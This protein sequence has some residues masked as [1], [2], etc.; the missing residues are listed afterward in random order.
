MSETTLLSA[1]VLGLVE[2]LTEFL[3]VSSTGHLILLVDLIGFQGPPGH[4]FEV[5]I[6]L[7]AIMAV[8]VVYF[9][10]LAGVVFGL[11]VDRGARQFAVAVVLAF[12]PAA[13]IGVALHGVIKSVL[14]DPTVVSVALIV[15]GVAI[16]AIERWVRPVP[17]VFAVEAIRPRTALAIGLFQCLAMVPGV[18]RAGATIIGSLLIGLERRVAAEFSFFLAIPTMLGASVYDL[19]KNRDALGL[20]DG[21]FVGG[22]V[23]A[24]GFAV[25]FVVAALVVQTLIAFISR[26]GFTPFGWYRIA[27]GGAMLT[28]LYWPAATG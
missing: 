27:L 16:L 18:S 19:Y 6:Q 20:V 5:V 7:G 1:A 24:V 9:R 3:P 26:H 4:V 10:R 14:F 28:L 22:W 8:C 17:R 2:G 12:L 13:V 15:G 25:A 11:P 23:I 21:A